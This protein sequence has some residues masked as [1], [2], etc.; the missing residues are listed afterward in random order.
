[1]HFSSG[2]T[3]SEEISDAFSA[4]LSVRSTAFPKLGLRFRRLRLLFCGEILRSPGR[5]FLYRGSPGWRACIPT[6]GPKLSAE[7]R[8]WERPSAVRSRG[9]GS[10]QPKDCRKQLAEK[11]RLLREWCATIE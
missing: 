3:I 9:N 6:A 11:S 10:V 4:R 1:M 8:L 7:K 2:T 5:S